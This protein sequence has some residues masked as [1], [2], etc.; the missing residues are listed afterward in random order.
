MTTGNNLSSAI[1]GQDDPNLTAA[2]I[3]ALQTKGIAAKARLKDGILQVTLV[4]APGPDQRTLSAI[5]EGL[6]GLDTQ[7]IKSVKIYGSRTAGRSGGSWG[8]ADLD[9]KN[10]PRKIK[11][12]R[13]ISSQGLD[14]KANRPS[15]SARQSPQWTPSAT[16]FPRPI[17]RVPQPRLHQ[18]L[19]PKAKQTRPPKKRGTVLL[20]VFFLSLGFLLA[21]IS[22][23]AL[24]QIIFVPEDSNPQ[25]TVSSLP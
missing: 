9:V 22:A 17:K 21:G 7:S 24:R 6:M 14:K 1:A 11:K 16:S 23:A 12:P 18:P 3:K 13:P 8:S 5:C 25:P 15:L 4:S 2:L 19:S 10:P 20:I